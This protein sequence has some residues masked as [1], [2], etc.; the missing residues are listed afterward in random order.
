MTLSTRRVGFI[1]LGSMGDCIRLAHCL[2]FFAFTNSD[3]TWLISSKWRAIRLLAPQIEFI[4][5][6][7]FR[8]LSKVF[9]R[10]FDIV[11]DFQRILKSG[12]ISFI[13]SKIRLGFHPRDTKE[14]N[15]LFNNIYIT[16]WLENQTKF[17]KYLELLVLAGLEQQ[18]FQ[19][20]IEP[21]VDK[22]QAVVSLGGSW[23]SKRFPK[24]ALTRILNA[25]TKLGVIHIFLLGGFDAKDDAEY[26]LASSKKFGLR[27][28][29]LV[30]IPLEETISFVKS[31]TP[32]YALGTD[33]GLAHLFA[34]FGKPYWTIFGPSDPR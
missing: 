32:G 28:N 6:N 17:E 4:E 15:H 19:T 34:Y 18:S 21:L 9:F 23:K 33:T 14:L 12:L 7:S 26:L 30:G 31:Y 24:D 3:I 10:K 5:V 16:P 27:V 2:K 1:L 25:L 20:T 22:S 13:S 8:A 29:N 11:V